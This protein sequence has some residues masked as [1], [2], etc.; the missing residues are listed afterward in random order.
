MPQIY[1]ETMSGRNMDR[2]ELEKCLERLEPGDTL[3]VGGWTGSGA[4]FATC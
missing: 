3:V 2:P 1:Q 4:R